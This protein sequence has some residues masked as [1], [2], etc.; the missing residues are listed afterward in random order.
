V[1]QIRDGQLRQITN[2]HTIGMLVWATDSL[3]LVLARHV[4]GRPDRRADMAL[5]NLRADGRYLW[6]TGRLSLVVEDRP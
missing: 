2:D 1:V 4:A 3:A 6:C 5:R